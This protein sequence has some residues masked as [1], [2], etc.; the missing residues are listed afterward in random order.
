MNPEIISLIASLLGIVLL[1]SVVFSAVVE[2][3]IEYAPGP[4]LSAQIVD[5]P[6]CANVSQS[7]AVK[8][9]VTNIGT[10]NATN[11]W[12]ALNLPSGW[13]STYTLNKTIGTLTPNQFGWNNV[14]YTTGT[15][16]SYTITATSNSSEGA[17]STDSKTVTVY[18][19]GDG[20]C[21]STC[22]NS[23]NCPGDCPTAVC[24]NGVCE[25][26]EDN[27]NCPGDCP[28][29]GPAGPGG[30]AGPIPQA[31]FSLALNPSTIDVYQTKTAQSILRVKNTGDA[32]LNNVRVN[33]TGL[34]S[35]W[36]S[37]EP[38][39][40]DRIIPGDTRSFILTFNPPTVGTYAFKINIK[41][42]E[43]SETVD[44]LLNVVELT[45]EINKTIE[46]EPKIRERVEKAMSIIRP[47]LIVSG[48]IGPAIIAFYMIFALAAERCPL[49]GAKTKVEY[50]GEYVIGYRCP[51]CKHFEI[52]EIRKK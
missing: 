23:V 36:Y 8:A 21:D 25:A 24:G 16:G 12:F 31:L 29:T 50:K 47:L 33:I 32:N 18:S 7:I 37:I 10:A 42:N 6:G 44:A 38:A 49:C 40:F 43:K 41:S 19:C 34:Q 28:V 27:T 9:K 30:P 22:E 15:R 11:V 45:P 51:N 46:E 5:Y 52:K 17:Y 4:S 3:T 35:G 2:I 48:M 20:N 26:G 14:T 39:S 1:S 13:S